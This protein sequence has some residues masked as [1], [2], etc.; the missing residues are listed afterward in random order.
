LVRKGRVDVS[1]P[2]PN[3][4][5]DGNEEAPQ[6]AFK[7]LA[8]DQYKRTADQLLQTE[9]DLIDTGSRVEMMEAESQLAAQKPRNVNEEAIQQRI[10]KEFQRDPEVAAL[11]KQ[12]GTV[13][14][15]LE[16]LKTL[17][18]KGQDPAVARTQKHR[19]R[20]MQDYQGLWDDKREEIRERLLVETSA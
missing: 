16:H 15:E 2:T 18:R 7:S 19:D 11:M 4:P 13:T 17:A 3:K 20:L 8:A 6:P 14:D 9:I 12:I 10:N 5:A 1:K